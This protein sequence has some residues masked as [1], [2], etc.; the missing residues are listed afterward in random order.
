MSDDI[1]V[2][3]VDGKD[4]ELPPAE[5]KLKKSQCLP[6]FM[7][8]YVNRGANAVIHTH[9]KSAVMATLLWPGKEV[10]LTHLEMIK[11]I[12]RRVVSIFCNVDLK[13]DVLKI[14]NLKN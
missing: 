14:R 8:V 12:R 9:S 10:V 3:D 1:F 7:C 5:K 4:L 6:L 13:Y 11:G 2:L